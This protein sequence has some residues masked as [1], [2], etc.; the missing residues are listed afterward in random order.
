MP[1]MR[2]LVVVTAL[3]HAAVVSADPPKPLVLQVAE[4]ALG[5]VDIQE[6]TQLLRLELPANWTLSDGVDAAAD[7]LKVGC[8][9]G[10]LLVT[11]E[12]ARWSRQI[13]SDPSR[14]LPSMRAR[15]MALATAELLRSDTEPPPAPVLPPT[16]PPPSLAPPPKTVPNR[17][18]RLTRDLSIGLGCGTVAFLAAG[19][20]LAVV[21]GTVGP[22][23]S[24]RG[25][26]NASGIILLSLAGA[27]L[28]G[29]VVSFAL[30][31]REHRRPR[32]DL[33]TATSP[34][35]FF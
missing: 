5:L 3:L 11:V 23:V 9:A 28:V 18:L 35:I 2:P 29:T 1:V 17:G 8:T 25:Q 21:G 27:T 16:P 12:H 30:W 32:R 20:P 7:L 22:E 15:T 33:T 6:F 31:V 4:C 14:E 19:I 10:E 26:I 13:R 34:A 24:T